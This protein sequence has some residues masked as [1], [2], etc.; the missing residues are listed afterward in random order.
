MAAITSVYCG[1]FHDVPGVPKFFCCSSCHD[2]NSE[3]DE[4]AGGITVY[5]CCGLS[6]ALATLP[7]ADWPDLFKKAFALQEAD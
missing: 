3:L 6:T 5:M 7:E 1:A 2:D 4:T